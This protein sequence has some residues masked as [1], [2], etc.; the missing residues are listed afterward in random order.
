MAMNGLFGLAEVLES[1]G[2]SP[3]SGGAPTGLP[4]A[5]AGKN[6]IH[7]DPAIGRKA[8]VSIERMLDFAR[9]MNLPTRGIG[10]A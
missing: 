8:K 3:R 5:G 1:A 9:Q 4:L 2:G 10:N 6:E 7:V